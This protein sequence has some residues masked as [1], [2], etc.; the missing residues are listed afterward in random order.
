MLQS[1]EG[2]VLITTMRLRGAIFTVAGN[3]IAGS[4]RRKAETRRTL[5]ISTG[6]SSALWA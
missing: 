2:P 1:T 6:S 4:T 3:G 5:M